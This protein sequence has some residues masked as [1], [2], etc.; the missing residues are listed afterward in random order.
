VP[1]VSP[2]PDWI[3]LHQVVCVVEGAA[4]FNTLVV[5]LFNV[6]FKV[7]FKTLFVAL[8]IVLFAVAF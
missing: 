7:L 8:L 1:R 3:A 2:G 5:V 4:P 6:L